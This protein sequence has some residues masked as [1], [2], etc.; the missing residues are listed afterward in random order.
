MITDAKRH[1]V[2]RLQRIEGA[3]ANELAEELGLTGSAVRQHLDA[4]AELGLVVA[5]DTRPEGRGRPAQRWEL[6]PLAGSLF[7]DRHAELTV[8]ML[9]LVRE[10]FGD[11]GLDRLIDARTR[12]QQ[13][14]YEAA[15]RPA[16]TV[17]ARARRLADIRSAEGYAAEVVAAP[18]GDGMLLVEHHCPICEA[19]EACQGF[20]RGE[21]E[22]FRSVLPGTEIEREQ[23]ILD[24]DA[25][26]T[27]RIRS[28]RRQIR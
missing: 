23:H 1:I 14:A 8:G 4:L 17:A 3:T 20:C 5:H 21:L 12:H 22:L 13:T 11:S 2:E 16:R 15:L 19:A 28:P 26:C 18:D 27:Y 10:E 7:P 6:T 25:R 24:G 9:D